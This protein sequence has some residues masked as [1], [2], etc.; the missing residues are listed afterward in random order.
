MEVEKEARELLVEAQTRSQQLQLLTAQKTSIDLQISEIE[1]A[2]KSLEGKEEAFKELGGILIKEDAKSLIE[3][4]KEKKELLEIQKK[5]FEKEEQGV[6]DRL[7]EIEERLREFLPS[8]QG[9]AG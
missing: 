6:K 5:N 2:I 8:Q 1:E 3:E 4:L 9:G 7:K